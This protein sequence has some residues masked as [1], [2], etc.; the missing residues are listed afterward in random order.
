M[1]CSYKW[2]VEATLDKN[3]I[4]LCYTNKA[5]P[6]TKALSNNHLF[7]HDI[8]MVAMYTRLGSQTT[9]TYI[10]AVVHG[11]NLVDISPL[12]AHICWHPCIDGRVRVLHELLAVHSE[13]E[14]NTLCHTLF[15]K[16]ATVEL[17][18]APLA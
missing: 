17:R 18:N 16:L 9:C 11:T 12:I 1:H 2:N 7:A 4:V 15:T 8:V 5:H 10:P 14:S 13:E 6:S 3:V